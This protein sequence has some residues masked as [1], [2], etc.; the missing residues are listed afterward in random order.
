MANV[1]II[2]DSPALRE[3]WSMSL[4]LNGHQVQTARTGA[5]ALASVAK[6]APDVMLCDHHLSDTTGIEMLSHLRAVSSAKSIYIIITSGNVGLESAAIN[7][8]AD[9]FLPKPFSITQLL[10]LIE[11]VRS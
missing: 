2:E 5:E 9:Y 3:V 8:G 1:L 4:A 10:D 7:A 11:H 6:C